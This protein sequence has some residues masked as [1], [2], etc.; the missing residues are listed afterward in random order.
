MQVARIVIVGT[1]GSGK[2]TLARQVAR[3]K[4]IPHIELDALHWEPNW[5]E[6]ST[7]VF[8]QR[9]QNALSAPGWAVDGNYSKARDIIWGKADMVVWLDYSLP[10]MLSRILRRTARR[11]LTS[12]ELWRGTGNHESLR[13]AFSRDSIILWVLTTYRKHR[14]QYPALLAQP[15]YKHLK[16]VRLRSPKQ[17]QRWLD[18]LQ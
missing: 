11:I 1:S 10:V 12:E 4:G 18:S 8:R 17:A 3:K 2:T 15:E 5:A 7:E 9:V 14:K 16:K 6:A 13:S